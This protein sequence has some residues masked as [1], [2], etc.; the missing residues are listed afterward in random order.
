MTLTLS[1]NQV[2]DKKAE[3][4]VSQTIILTFYV[5]HPSKNTSLKMAIIGG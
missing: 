5:I 1:A 3:N 4:S 2:E